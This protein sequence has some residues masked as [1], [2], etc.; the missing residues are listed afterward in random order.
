[1]WNN[2]EYELPDGTKEWRTVD[3]ETG[4]YLRFVAQRRDQVTVM[5]LVCGGWTVPFDTIGN[6]EN[7]GVPEKEYVDIS[8]I[9]FPS[10]LSG[11]FYHIDSSYPEDKKEQKR[12]LDSAIE[13]MTIF[14]SYYNGDKRPPGY[15]RVH[16][17]I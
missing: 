11:G 16:T 3:S 17:R 5:V 14:G 4:A 13:A 1:M 9:C 8:I 2:I 7:E 15:Y 6:M 12:I 10:F